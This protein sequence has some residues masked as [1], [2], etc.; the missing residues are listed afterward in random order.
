MVGLL[1][2]AGIAI[3]EVYRPQKEEE[4]REPGGELPAPVTGQYSQQRELER[5][6]AAFREEFDLT[7]KQ[8]EETRSALRKT[9][10]DADK[11]HESVVS[12]VSLMNNHQPEEAA[13]EE[14]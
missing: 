6:L 4:Y 3:L 2:G 5:E 1:L 10:R 12:F 7:R 8:L 11:V 13:E 14:R 9:Q